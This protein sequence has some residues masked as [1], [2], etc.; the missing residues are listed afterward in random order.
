M[1]LAMDAG[2]SNIVLG[3][4][5]GGR[6][7][8]TARAATDR[9]R[10]EDEYAVLF[11]SILQMNGINPSALEGGILSS[12]VP[13]LNR[14]LLQAGE[15]II[16]K[17][18]LLVEPGIRTGLP[19]L[20]DNPAALGSDR[21]VDAVAASA[22]YPKPLIIFDLGTCTTV[23]VV[24]KE[25]AFRGGVICAGVR[26]SQEA[27]AA[28]TSQLPAISLDPPRRAIGRNTIDCMK[29]GAIYGTAALV[30]GL[31]ERIERELGEPATVV[32]TGGMGKRILPACRKK[33]RNDG[34]LLLKCLW[35]IY[36][37]NQEGA[38]V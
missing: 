12:V 17:R 38:A 6:V 26:I 35:L 36:Q 31:A 30:D 29:S 34:D 24:D 37:K 19:L 5:E 27:L 33:I 13:P 1:I 22:L 4:L 16:G 8:L 18:P 23:S 3:C 10:T 2:N 7:V 28:Q 14:T 21:I 15:R 32:M 11:R 20:V 25:G 9:Q